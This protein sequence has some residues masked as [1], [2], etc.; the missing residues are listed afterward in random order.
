MTRDVHGQEKRP[1]SCGVLT[2]SDTR[3]LA[4]D[5]SGDRIVELL[6]GAGH[7]VTQRALIADDPAALQAEIARFSAYTPTVEVLISTGGTGFSRRDITCDVLSG[8]FAKTLPGFGELFRSLSYAEIGA[9][10]MLS[11][12]DAG[13]I[14]EMVV[15]A[16]PGSRAA[17]ETAMTRLI[18]PELSHLVR[19]VRE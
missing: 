19:L 6:L 12:A 16:L 1:V 11:R 15:F 13:L 5:A 9:R 14:G 2:L 7:T 3:T 17:V 18:L 8:L 4:T 10:A